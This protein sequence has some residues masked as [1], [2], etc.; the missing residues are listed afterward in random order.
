MTMTEDERELAMVFAS[1]IKNGGA[2]LCMMLERE[3]DGFAR[4]IAGYDVVFVIWPDNVS[5]VGVSAMPIKLTPPNGCD[6]RCNSIPCESREQAFALLEQHG[7]DALRAEFA[8]FATADV[9]PF[10]R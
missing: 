6:A 4:Y 2:A 5:K 3:H 8:N 7:D 9:I 10:P 1:A